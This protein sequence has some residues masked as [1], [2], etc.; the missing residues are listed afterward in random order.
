MPDGTLPMV[1]PILIARDGTANLLR[2][3]AK[4]AILTL[5]GGRSNK[6]LAVFGRFFPAASVCSV[7]WKKGQLNVEIPIPTIFPRCLLLPVPIL[8]PPLAEVLKP[9][10]ESQA[11][12]FRV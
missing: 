3:A 6:L 11:G 8:D 7:M 1:I 2:A 10:E 12:C 4:A 5:A 9:D